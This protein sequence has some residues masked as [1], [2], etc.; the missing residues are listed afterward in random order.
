[1]CA[2]RQIKVSR[3]R[4]I[5]YMSVV[6]C[7]VVSLPWLAD[8]TPAGVFCMCKG[9]L[10]TFFCHMHWSVCVCVC[11]CVCVC[12]TL[13]VHVLAVHPADCCVARPLCRL[14]AHW[15]AGLMPTTAP[16]VPTLKRMK[17]LSHT[18]TH[19]HTHT[20]TC[21]SNP[22]YNYPITWWIFTYTADPVKVNAVFIQLLLCLTDLN[23]STPLHLNLEVCN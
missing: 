20:F 6:L 12:V 1:M 13:C 2:W 8:R 10:C 9:R 3:P 17:E 4:W 18:H 5:S 23:V 7:C 15:F 22:P 21:L 11:A 14:L 19:T 16:I